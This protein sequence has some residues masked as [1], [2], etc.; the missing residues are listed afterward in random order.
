[1]LSSL[2]KLG[3]L[4][5]VLMLVLQV[6]LEQKLS[7]M[8]TELGTQLKQAEETQVKIITPIIIIIIVII[9]GNSIFSISNANSASSSIYKNICF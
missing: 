7:S 5:I 9:T 4:D 1:M 2:L 6:K 8:M 3:F